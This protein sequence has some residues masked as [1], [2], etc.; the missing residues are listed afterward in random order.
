MSL[1]KAV[2]STIKKRPSLIITP[3]LEEWLTNNPELALRPQDEEVFLNLLRPSPNQIRTGR[4]GA[5]SRGTCKRRQVFGYL[6]MPVAKIRDPQLQAIFNDG[7]FRH[8]RWQLTLLQAGLIDRVEHRFRMTKYKLKVSLDG[9]K[10]D[11][12]YFVEV[13]GMRSYASTMTDVDKHHN[14]QIHTCMLASGIDTAVYIP[15][16]KGTN[17]WREIVIHRDEKVIEQVRRELK[18][19]NRSVDNMELPDVKN[20]CYKKVGEYKS[21]PYAVLC[22]QHE[23]AGDPWPLNGKWAGL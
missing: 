12:G 1:V 22:L 19:L 7:K 3:R 18:S 14:L 16:E 9:S 10:R 21:C 4:F 5:S 13:K 11:D 17:D 23:A 15:E 6:G 20:E 8:I 2:K